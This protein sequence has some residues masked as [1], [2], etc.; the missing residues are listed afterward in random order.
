VGGNSESGKSL[1]LDLNPSQTFKEK[2][3]PD[4]S[5]PTHGEAIGTSR[6]PGIFLARKMSRS[7][8]PACS[9]GSIPQK[10]LAHSTST[11]CT[12]TKN[13][14]RRPDLQ[15]PEGVEMNHPPDVTV[16]AHIEDRVKGKIG[17]K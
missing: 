13:R 16:I 14:D 4:R 12:W 1:H 5:D 10:T 9:A 11:D 8:N 2:I 15:L 17:D 7:R 3:E 6:R